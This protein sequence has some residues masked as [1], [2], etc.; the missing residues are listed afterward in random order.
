[1]LGAARSERA[2]RTRAKGWDG[3]EGHAPVTGDMRRALSR[4]RQGAGGAGI[5]REPRERRD[6]IMRRMLTGASQTKL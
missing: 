6:M 5:P 1:M 3:S 2:A 4:V